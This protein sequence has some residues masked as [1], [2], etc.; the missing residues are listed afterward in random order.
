MNPEEVFP[1][2]QAT[3]ARQGLCRQQEGAGI[4]G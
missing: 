3:V 2:K 4:S 1:E